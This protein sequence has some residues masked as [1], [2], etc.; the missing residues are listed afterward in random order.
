MYV[1]R[2]EA[3]SLK[4]PE[5]DLQSRSYQIGWCNLVVMAEG[6]QEDPSVRLRRR[7]SEHTE[8]HVQMKFLKLSMLYFLFH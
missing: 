3:G 8:Y 7:R 5:Y 1:K 4:P 6:T 2:H